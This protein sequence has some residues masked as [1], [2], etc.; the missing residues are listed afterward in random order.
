M[1]ARAGG[2][3][4]AR[5]APGTLGTLAGGV[6]LAWAL[7]YA[8]TTVQWLVLATVFVLASWAAHVAERALQTED[9]GEIVI[10]E[11]V[12]YL[13]TMVGVSHTWTSVI[14]GFFLF[15]LFDICKPW[16]VKTMERRFKGGLA[17]VMDDVAAGAYAHA[18]LLLILA[19]LP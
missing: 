17:V 14:L 7:S 19:S 2:V 8:P 18:F 1:V 13:V 15:R 3:G 9:P 10:D 12:G 11:V 5:R 6:P 4:K 16:P